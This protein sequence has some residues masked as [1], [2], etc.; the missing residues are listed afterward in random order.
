MSLF[1]RLCMRI[2]CFI[3]VLALSNNSGHRRQNE[4]RFLAFGFL[5]SNTG[6]GNVFI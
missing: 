1:Y 2:A 3:S 5:I 4:N 6:K